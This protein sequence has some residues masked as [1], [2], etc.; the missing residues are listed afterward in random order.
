MK[1]I[2]LTIAV[3]TLGLA[4][5]DKDEPVDRNYSTN[6]SVHNDVDECPRADGTP[7]R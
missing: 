5:C 6:S 7:C 1:K 2:A 3:L 4:A